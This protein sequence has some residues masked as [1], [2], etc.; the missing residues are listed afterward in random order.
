MVC[1]KGRR[2]SDRKLRRGPEAIWISLE[3]GCW[4]DSHS[5]PATVNFNQNASLRSH[6]C[7]PSLA[8]RFEITRSLSGI[9]Q[10]G[11]FQ[12]SLLEIP[13]ISQ[14]RNQNLLKPLIIKGLAAPVRH[15]QQAETRKPK[16]AVNQKIP[17]IFVNHPSLHPSNLRITLFF[18]KSR[19]A[20]L[21]P[22]QKILRFNR[23]SA[24]RSAGRNW[25]QPGLLQLSFDPRIWLLD[26]LALR[27]QGRRAFSF[28]P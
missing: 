1:R 23:P 13:K 26:R 17:K 5:T 6:R 25:M 10:S 20:L 22:P 24:S 27:S 4:Q 3:V 12:G 28:S 21:T 18:C 7:S 11:G 19:P 2:M 14:F 15:K 9:Y 16:L 8:G